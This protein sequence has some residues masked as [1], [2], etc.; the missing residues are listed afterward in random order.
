MI[1]FQKRQP[2]HGFTLIELLIVVAIIAILAA[3]AVPNFLE[4]Q[5]RSKVARVKSDLRTQAT[6]MEAY[7]VDWNHLCRD[8]DSDL[9]RESAFS[10][11]AFEDCARGAVQLTTPVAYMTSILGDPFSAGQF[12]S[13]TGGVAYGYRI[14]SGDWSY[15]SSGGTHAGQ[16]G[17]ADSQ[18]AAATMAKYGPVKAYITLSPGP[19][20]TRNRMSYKCFP[21]KPE[22]NSDLKPP[23]PDYY[24][25]YDPT[26]GTMSNGDIMRF[27]GSFL[28]GNWDRNGA[29]AGPHG[30]EAN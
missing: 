1:D 26:N 25:D 5:T 27:G 24:E 2:R 7:A 4:A 29:N 8:S 3:I 30:P 13:A 15:G 17:A 9:D 23:L 20:K 22:G 28:Q 19:D 10:G 18:N 12:Q 6:A 11:W 16:E 14:G 21:F